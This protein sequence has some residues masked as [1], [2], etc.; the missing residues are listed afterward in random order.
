MLSYAIVF[1][2]DIDLTSAVISE[3][4]LFNR[5]IELI[6]SQSVRD[7]IKGILCFQTKFLNT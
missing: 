2:P 6:F 7:L 4:Q 3:E 1:I 5:I